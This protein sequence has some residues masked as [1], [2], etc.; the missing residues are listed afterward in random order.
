MDELKTEASEEVEIKEVSLADTT[1]APKK[2]KSIDWLKVGVAGTLA[3]SVLSLGLSCAAL[4]TKNKDNDS[5]SGQ[6]SDSVNHGAGISVSKD[7]Y[8]VINGK[9]TNIKSNGTTNDIVDAQIIPQD[10]W[11]IATTIQF[12]YSDGMVVETEEQINVL[13]DNY[14]EV[15]SLDDLQTLQSY[16]VSRVRLAN[17]LSVATPLTFNKNLEID[18][19]RK[20][21][22]YT[23]TTP[24]KV[25][26]NTAL[27]ID[28]GN[29]NISTTK[30]LLL[31]GANSTLEIFDT[32]ISANGIVAEIAG[33]ESKLEL[34]DSKI[35]AK[36]NNNSSMFKVSSSNSKMIVEDTQISCNNQMIESTDNANV[37]LSVTDLTLESADT[38]VTGGTFAYNPMTLGFVA[39]GYQ[40]FKVDNT[41]VVEDCLADVIA[42]ADAGSTIALEADTTIPT[43]INIAK[44]ITIDL[45]GHEITAST[46]AFNITNGEVEIDNGTIKTTTAHALYV[47]ATAAGADLTLRLGSSLVVNSDNCC[48]FIKGP[49]AKLETSATLFSNGQFAALSGNGNEGNEVESISITGGSITHTSYLAIYVPQTGSL[50]ISGGEI[51][52]TTALYIKSGNLNI[53]GGSFVATGDYEGYVYNGNGTSFAGDALIIDACDY[54]GGNPVVTITGGTFTAQDA[55]GH[56]IGYYA[57]N[58][59]TAS[60]TA[61]G[62]DI[63]ATT[64]VSTE[65]A[66]VAALADTT[67]NHI[68]LADNITITQTINLDRDVVIDLNGKT[69]TANTKAFNI[70]NGEVEIDSGTI[71]TTTAHALYVD[72]T[73]PGADLTLRLGSSLVVNSDN[74][75]VFIKGPG[76]KLETAATLF[77]NGQFAALSGNGNE[78][79]EVESISITGGSITHTS[80]LAIYVPQTGSLNI[81][82][83]EITGTTAL[84]VKS[85]NLNISGG[86]FVATGDYEGYVY[87]GDG[88]SFV[89]D[90]LII[91]ACG[92]PGGNPVVTIT[93][94]TFTA[95]DADGHGIGYYA[96][97]ENTATI[98]A[99]GYDI[100]TENH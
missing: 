98:T 84:Y 21:L 78:G 28:N 37:D 18:L 33:N 50:N 24:I 14:Y 36:E 26:H 92:Y 39:D 10:K 13:R 31:E 15:S 2:K 66:F 11:G 100:H 4:I 47:D 44:D 72:A 45:N 70:T 22:L 68:T 63:Y 48:V 43:T 62:Y 75:C 73:A 89:G 30:G 64:C 3:C 5:K 54:P 91:D 77:S 83:G 16:G 82:G 20:T 51:T 19:N 53:S 6:S 56:G 29:L 61:V 76:A 86:S 12:V 55:D 87:D 69:I 32:K 67:I 1:E 60:I 34:V 90:A 23:A 57:Y 7:G 65:S 74:C 59:N 80:Y 99:T 17:S 49:G 95:Q 85:G 93:G 35:T 88:T 25:K 38:V 8:L 9:K 46:K 96:Y 40:V 81:S 94:G 41:W 97:G 71:Q 52:G 79:N 27:R 58:D 42:A